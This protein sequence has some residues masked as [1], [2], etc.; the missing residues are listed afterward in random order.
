MIKSKLLRD[1]LPNLS[2][3]VEILPICYSLVPKNDIKEQHIMNI[4]YLSCSTLL[5][6]I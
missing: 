4:F 2:H 6:S 3:D 1:K 5:I